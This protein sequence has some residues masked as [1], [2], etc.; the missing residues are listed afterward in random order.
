MGGF[1][2]AVP[3]QDIVRAVTDCADRTIL[4]QSGCT[5]LSVDLLSKSG[6]QGKPR[7]NTCSSF[8]RCWVED[9]PLI[10][11]VSFSTGIFTAAGKCRLQKEGTCIGN[12]ISPVVSRLPVLMAEQIF[13][14]SLLHAVFSSL[15]FLRYVDNRLILAPSRIFQYPQ[16]R[17]FCRPDFNKGIQLESV[18]DHQWLGVTI[19]ASAR[20]ATFNPPKKPWQI[21]SPASAGSWRLAASGF[22]SR[23]ALIH[24][25]AWPTESVLPEIQAL[26]E[27][28]VQAGF[29]KDSVPEESKSPSPEHLLDPVKA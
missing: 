8:E 19:H 28:Y 12:Q 14:K 17:E 21:R 22:F 23:A 18:E 25:Y 11:Q 1:F 2:N 3:R 26:Q 16:I 7:G 9:I 24:Q 4:E 27:I 6:H 29:L 5:A 20:T 13:L 15:L 10:V